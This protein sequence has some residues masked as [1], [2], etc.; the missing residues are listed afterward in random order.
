MST[1]VDGQGSVATS[2]T[3]EEFVQRLLD[4]VLGDLDVQAAYL[5][6]RLG[7]YR[8]LAE[9]DEGLTSRS[10]PR[11]A[12]PRSATPANGSSSRPSPVSSSRAGT[13][14]R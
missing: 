5:G 4:A 2:P 1:T 8:L 9:H 11:A 10:S 3:A 14:T 7:Y 12:A 13:A 6:D